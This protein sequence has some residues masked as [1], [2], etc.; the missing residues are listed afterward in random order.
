MFT[1]N[2]V[3]YRPNLLLIFLT[4]CLRSDHCGDCGLCS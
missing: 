1:N 2:T 4:I 3:Y